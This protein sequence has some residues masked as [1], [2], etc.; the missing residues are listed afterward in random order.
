MIIVGLGNYGEKYEKTRHNMGFM[1]VETLAKGMNVNF[2]NK[3][4]KSLTATGY[5]NSE[6]YCIAKPQTYMNLSGEAVKELKGKYK[7][8][9]DQ[10]VV[11][12]DDIDL[13]L[14]AVRI[15]KTGGAGTH[16]GLK[17]I[18][19]ELGSKDFLRIRMGVGERTNKEMD[20]ATYVLSKFSKDE[21][22]ILEDS[23]NKASNAC[24]ELLEGES[25]ENVMQ[26][27]NKK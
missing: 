17:N 24:K 14:G 1:V 27:Y 22:A 11:V 5:K 3:E 8:S 10:I 12:S 15:R 19:S 23:I 20:L 18:I 21:F 9:N 4:C 13:P 25:L 6:K 2:K 26:V 7:V 16:N